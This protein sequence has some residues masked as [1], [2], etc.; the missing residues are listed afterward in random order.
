MRTRIIPIIALI[1][2]VIV[3]ILAPAIAGAQITPRVVVAG[4]KAPSRLLPLENGLVLVAENGDG[5]NTGRVSAIT[6]DARRLVLIDGLPSGMSPPN[7]TPSGVGGLALRNRTLY[8]AIGPGDATLNGPAPGTEIR[9]PNPSS[10]IFSSVLALD[11]DPALDAVRGPFTV[12]PAQHAA[13]KAGQTVA[14]TNE[15]GEHAVLRM[16]GDIADYQDEPRPDAPGNTRG[17]NPF[18]LEPVDS[19]GLVMVDA[20]RNVL[21]RVDICTNTIALAATFPQ[22]PNP[23]PTGP[24]LIDAVPTSARAY[25]GDVLVSLLTG[26]PFPAGVAEVRR[27]RLGSG[28][29]EPIFTGLHMLIDVLPQ[30]DPEDGFFV[31]EYS[32]DPMTGVPGRVIWYDSPHSNGVPIASGLITPTHMA[33]DPRTGELLVCEFNT[34]RVLAIPV[35][36]VTH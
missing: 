5:P 7:N 19:C 28:L 18:G 16:V 13:L 26:A 2:S 23:L 15:A 27:V 21:W 10:P 11:F 30:P 34:G 1:L 32:Q 3:S 9:N 20:A 36:A 6:T 4:L 22:Y 14:L 24:R 8:I 31:L 17:S 29:S 12:V 35:R 33:V 25:Q